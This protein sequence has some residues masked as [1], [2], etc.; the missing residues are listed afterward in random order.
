MEAQ[1]H[2]H[3]LF[4]TLN[5]L[6]EMIH[7][8]PRAA[9]TMVIR[10]ADLL[11][12]TLDLSEDREVPLARELQVLD[13]Y[14]EL[15]RMRFGDRLHTE[16]RIAPGAREALAP[17]LVLQPLVENAL[18]HGLAGQPGVGRLLVAA[19]IEDGQL[20]LIV[21]D[22]GV[23]LRHPVREGIG[24]RNTRDRLRE[25]YGE[26]SRFTLSQAAGGKGTEARIELP[27]RLG[28]PT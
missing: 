20:V 12:L 8:D 7:I 27:A 24:L 6:S 19:A 22:D 26:A 10:L 23:G 5:T 18:R 28:I 14:L 15:Q 11:R 16:L 21:R 3:F 17:P 9:D 13:A 25:Q 1:L 2:P 4:N